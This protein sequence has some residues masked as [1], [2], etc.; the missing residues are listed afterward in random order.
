MSVPDHELDEFDRECEQCGVLS[1]TRLCYWC[2]M[3]VIDLY[4]EEK[5]FDRDR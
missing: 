5:E 4:G 3:D 2:R 1:K